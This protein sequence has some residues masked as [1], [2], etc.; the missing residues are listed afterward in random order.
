MNHLRVIIYIC[1]LGILIYPQMLFAKTEEGVPFLINNGK[2]PNTQNFGPVSSDE[3]LINALNT[4]IPEVYKD[5]NYKG[6]KV[7][8]IAHL[9]KSPHPEAYYE[10]AKN[11][12]GEELA[13]NSWFVEVLFPQYLPAYD[14]SH[15]QIFVTKN[16]QGQWFAWFRFH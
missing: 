6:W 13:N 9:P 3:G 7:E 2:C 1:I 15:R 12:C 5:S 8:T 14:A 10:M 11:Y 16:K 4:I